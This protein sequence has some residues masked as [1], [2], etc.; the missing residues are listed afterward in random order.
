MIKYYYD[1]FP[2]IL[3]AFCISKNRFACCSFFKTVNKQTNN[4]KIIFKQTLIK[5]KN[6]GK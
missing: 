3:D 1:G 6:N 5:D 2:F 4:S